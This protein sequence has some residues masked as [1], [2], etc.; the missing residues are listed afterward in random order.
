MNQKTFLQLIIASSFIS[1]FSMQAASNGEKQQDSNATITPA[2]TAAPG[3][4]TSQNLQPAQQA[5]V[6]ANNPN[7]TTPNKLSIKPIFG[8][9]KFTASSTPQIQSAPPVQTQPITPTAEA[10]PQSSN[11][12]P[13]LP[14]QK[15]STDKNLAQAQTEI[16]KQI[17]KGC[18]P[19]AVQAYTY[20]KIYIYNNTQSSLYI[21]FE[22]GISLS[23][24]PATNSSPENCIQVPDNQNYIIYSS[25]NPS[26]KALHLSYQSD[27]NKPSRKKIIA[28]ECITRNGSPSFEKKD[29]QIL[30]GNAYI[31]I[32]PKTK[33][34]AIE[35]K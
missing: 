20:P 30:T 21:G 29:P 27:E 31:S 22:G 10:Q 28:Q 18:H 33:R 2:P 14:T 32:D 1:A 15:S 4:P 25:N 8:G 3:N 35:G 11:P 26:G 34:L 12:A 9:G 7:P 6:S 24:I 23:L 19:G 16:I 17:K 13:S 5:P